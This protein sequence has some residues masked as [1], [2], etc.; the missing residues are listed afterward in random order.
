MPNKIVSG[1][2]HVEENNANLAAQDALQDESSVCQ[3]LPLYIMKMRLRIS[4]VVS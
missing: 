3:N 2:L 1:E 4:L